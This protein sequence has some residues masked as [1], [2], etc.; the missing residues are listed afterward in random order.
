M[1]ETLL[2]VENLSLSYGRLPA[3]QQVSLSLKRGESLVIVGESGSG[4]SSL[5]LAV[6]RLLPP[7]AAITGGS[8]RFL[9]PSGAS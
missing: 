8:I 7:T 1:S 3:L 4:K 9:G 6:M 5:G 2:A